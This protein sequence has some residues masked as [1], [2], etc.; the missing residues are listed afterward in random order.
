[1]IL[2]L[3]IRF[4]KYIVMPCDQ[5]CH[6][7]QFGHCSHNLYICQLFSM[8]EIQWYLWIELWRTR[9]LVNINSSTARLSVYGS[10]I[11]RDDRVNAIGNGLGWGREGSA[12]WLRS[13][14][15]LIDHTWKRKKAIELIALLLRES[16]IWIHKNKLYF[17]WF[18]S[19]M[20]APTS[21]IG[22]PCLTG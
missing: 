7:M 4:V 5:A 22:W 11:L 9:K 19:E 15:A 16:H 17:V 12:G 6:M 14:A 18:L 10:N 3:R 2:V 21:Q 8:L 13:L 20:G 1:M